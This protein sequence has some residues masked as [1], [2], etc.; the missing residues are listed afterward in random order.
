MRS[1]A[2]VHFE[3]FLSINLKNETGIRMHRKGIK[4]TGGKADEA[5]IFRGTQTDTPEKNGN[6]I[7]TVLYD[8]N[9]FTFIDTRQCHRRM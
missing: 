9:V 2:S 6:S 4:C 3:F 8:S 5:N 1:M 7:E